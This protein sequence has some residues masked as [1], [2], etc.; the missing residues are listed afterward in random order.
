MI[1][2]AA[3]IANSISVCVGDKLMIAT[4]SSPVAV[5]SAVVS[6]DVSPVVSAVVSDGFTLS[7]D[8]DMESSPQAAA[9]SR[10]AVSAA[11]ELNRFMDQSSVSPED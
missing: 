9:V 8:L 11:S 5:V 3:P 10:S 1:W 6:P 4:G 2:S 7:V